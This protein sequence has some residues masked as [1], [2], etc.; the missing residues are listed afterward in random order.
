MPTQLPVPSPRLPDNLIYFSLI[1]TPG[2]LPQSGSVRE[3]SSDVLTF[4]ALAR[5]D[6]HTTPTPRRSLSSDVGSNRYRYAAEY[7]SW[8]PSFGGVMTK[9]ESIEHE[10]QKL[11][12]GELAQ[13]RDWFLEHDWRAWDRQIE[14]DVGTVHSMISQPK[15]ST[16]TLAAGRKS[17][18][19]SVI[20]AVLEAVR[21]APERRSAGGPREFRTTEGQSPASLPSFQAHRAV[22]VR[23]HRPRP[24]SGWCRCTRWHHVVLDWRA[25]RIPSSHPLAVGAPHDSK[26][27]VGS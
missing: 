7:S 16:K 21:A 2:A 9:V 12:P 22:L 15:L 11:S 20:P 1:E 3:V 26:S 18:E 6:C 10:V 14:R 19:P 8:R 23:A 13:F 4:R 17:F 24:S 5:Y 27:G 25:Q